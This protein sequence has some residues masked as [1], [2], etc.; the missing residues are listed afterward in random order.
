MMHDVMMV[1]RAPA[2]R[3]MLRDLAS[4]VAACALAGCGA[5]HSALVPPVHAGSSHVVQLKTPANPP[6]PVSLA[7]MDPMPETFD[8]N[9]YLPGV[10]MG[11]DLDI[12]VSVYDS[13]QIAR[14]DSHGLVSAWALPADPQCLNGPPVCS[15]GPTDML[16]GP[17]GNMYVSLAQ[18]N[19]IAQVTPVGG[20]TI[21]QLDP[22]VFPLNTQSEEG[23]RGLAIG[24]DG[25][26][27]FNHTSASKI[28]RM[29]LSG[30][31][32]AAYAEPTSNSGGGRITAGPDGNMWFT[33]TAANNIGKLDVST[34]EITEYPTPT[35][36]S[37]P[38][39]IV[40][41]ADGN[42]WF[43][44]KEASQLGRITTA[45]TITEF[46]TPSK[47]QITKPTYMFSGPDGSLWFAE[48]WNSSIARVDPVHQTIVEYSTYPAAQIEPDGITTG[49]NGDV[50]TTDI[51]NDTLDAFTLNGG[52]P[53]RPL[54]RI[55]RAGSVR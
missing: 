37:Y 44:E 39:T 23:P 14:F 25:N 18:M 31:P 2:R 29:T 34:G 12:W 20:I 24:P 30:T 36:G 47:Q 3:S 7:T 13:N 17:D 46:N 15:A 38:H 42:L 43:T 40:A 9:E 50:W 49:L 52:P 19:A 32:I 35:A 41:A 16:L 8:P 26:L 5:G 28:G 33:E 54:V 6:V 21:Y 11:S 4:V 27:W 48:K 1:D 51:I 55:R 53:A 45:G 22:N 10:A